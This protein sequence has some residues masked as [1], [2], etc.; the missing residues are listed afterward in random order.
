MVVVRRPG[1]SSGRRR[2]RGIARGSE[3]GGMRLGDHQSALPKS[4]PPVRGLF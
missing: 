1:Y 2:Y 3:A 4:Q